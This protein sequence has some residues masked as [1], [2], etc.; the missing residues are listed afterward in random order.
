MAGMGKRLRPHTLTTPKPLLR[1]VGKPIVEHLVEEISLQVNGKIDAIAFV[2]G[3]FGKEVERDLLAIAQKV[4]AKGSIFYQEEALGTAHAIL[5]AKELLE[6]PVV[7][8]FADTLF[9]ADFK[10]DPNIDGVLWVEKVA[11]PSAF[12][13]VELDKEGHITSFVEKPQQFVSDKAMIGI[14]YFKKGELLRKE[15]EYLIDHKIMN[16]GEYQL[17]DALRSMV[18]KGMKFIP[19][20]VLEWLD[21]GNYKATVNTNGR[22]LEYKTGENNIAADL[23]LENALIIPPCYIG[24]GVEISHSVIGPYV[25][26]DGENRI[27]NTVIKNSIIGNGTQIKNSSI[28]DSMIG[29]HTVIANKEKVLSVGDFNQIGE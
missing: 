17:P 28:T 26:I 14:Y 22:W 8:A 5:C 1:L 9:R 3:D 6:G 29:N 11:D 19:G 21:C 24:K 4:G 18:E 13:V 20:T 25:S 7:V 15:M 23:K 12:G 10:I 27:E 16:D 2:I